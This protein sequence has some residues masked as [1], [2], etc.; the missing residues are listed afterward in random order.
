MIKP[1]PV[2]HPRFRKE[3]IRC[4]A[5][6]PA[7]LCVADGTLTATLKVRRTEVARRHA[8]LIDAMFAG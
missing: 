8:A 3:R 5:L 1:V 4:V 2:F 6:L 7:P